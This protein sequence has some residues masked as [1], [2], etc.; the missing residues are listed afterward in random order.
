MTTPTY[1]VPDNPADPEAAALELIVRLPASISDRLAAQVETAGLT[2]ILQ[3][4]CTV[5]DAEGAFS[6]LSWADAKPVA[7]AV[8]FARRRTT[9][10]FW[11]V[12]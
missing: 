3:D 10:S 9:M 1:T 11:L 4:Y 5:L 2:Q 8:C 7:A 6:G 12:L